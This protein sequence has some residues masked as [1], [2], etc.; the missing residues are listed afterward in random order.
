MRL[1]LQ[2]RKVR[3]LLVDAILRRLTEMRDI[4]KSGKPWFVDDMFAQGLFP[5][6]PLNP[7]TRLLVPEI[8]SADDVRN[9]VLVGIYA[10][11]TKRCDQLSQTNLTG[12]G[13]SAPLRN[14]DC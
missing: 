14:S 1:H 4:Q 11:R 10:P 2:M 12:H 5:H 7:V 13:R 6:L 3:V 9:A 8:Q